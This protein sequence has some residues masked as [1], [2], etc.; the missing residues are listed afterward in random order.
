[1]PQAERE[2]RVKRKWK[3]PPQFI[4]APKREKNTKNSQRKAGQED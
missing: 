1:M 2:A 4:I 3:A